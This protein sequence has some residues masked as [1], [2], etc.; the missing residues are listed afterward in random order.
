MRAAKNDVIKLVVKAPFYTG[1]D[2]C[3]YLLHVTGSGFQ[4][5]TGNGALTDSSLFAP[6]RVT[7]V[8]QQA[9]SW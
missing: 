3:G 7:G 9:L 1:Y 5:K 8:H 2:M 6:R 4:T